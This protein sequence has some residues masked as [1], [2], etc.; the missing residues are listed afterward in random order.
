MPFGLTNALLTFQ[1]LM[2]QVLRPFLRK[3]IL[4]FFDDILVYSSD[5]KEHCMHLSIVFEL[6]REHKLHLNRK[7]CHFAKEKVEYLSH[8]I[9]AKGVEADP[10][11]VRDIIDWP[12]PKDLKVAFVL[13]RFIK[14]YGRIAWPL[15]Q[16]LKKD[17]FKW[18]EEAR[19]AFEELK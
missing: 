4:V 10:T 11:K 14:N 19:R 1:T 3:C 8:I 15:T 12:L 5:W 9:L 16:V 18:G 6:L 13:R 7:K 17:N 2:N